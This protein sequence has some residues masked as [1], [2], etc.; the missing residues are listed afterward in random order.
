MLMAKTLQT[1][2]LILKIHIVLFLVLVSF[3]KSTLAQTLLL[4]GD[5]VFVSVNSSNNSFE[6]VPLIDLT[7][8]TTFEINNGLWNEEKHEF[9]NAE[10]LQ[11]TAIEAVSAGS[12]IYVEN[13][14]TPSFKTKGTLNIAKSSNHLF[15]YQKEEIQHRFIYAIGWQNQDKNKNSFQRSD[16]PLALKEVENSITE[17]SG[18][19]NYQYFIR[20]G[21]S[22]TP[23]MIRRFVANADHWKINNQSFKNLGTSFKLLKSPVINFGSSF[24]Q[25]NENETKLTLDVNIF[26]HDGSK[27][28]VD[29]VFDSVYSSITRNRISNYITQKVNFTGL[30]GDATKQIVL[31][32]VDDE[33]YSGDETAI[34]TLEN[35]S[36][37]SFGDFNNHTVI[38][39]EDEIPELK[40]EVVNNNESQFLLI[41]NLERNSVDVSNWQISNGDFD[42]IFEKGQN[43]EVGETLFITHNKAKEAVS[44]SAIL[45]DDESYNSLFVGKTIHLNNRQIKKVAEYAFPS[46]DADKSGNTEVFASNFSDVNTVNSEN[47]AVQQKKLVQ[48][49][50]L[51]GWKHIPLNDFESNNFDDIELKYW[52]ESK[53][54]FQKL[55]LQNLPANNTVLVGYF[56]DDNAERLRKLETESKEKELSTDLLTLSLSATDANENEKLDGVEGFSLVTNNTS[57]ALN[58]QEISK[59]IKTKL[60]LNIEPQLFKSNSS[61]SDIRS[62]KN[63]FILPNQQFWV[64]LN[65]KVEAQVIDINTSE[66]TNNVELSKK[67]ENEPGITLQLKG[68]FGKEFI[69]LNFNSD[70]E[71]ITNTINPSIYKQLYLNEPQYGLF[72]INMME[73][74]FSDYTI[75]E[76]ADYSVSLPLQLGALNDEELTISIQDWTEVPDDWVVQ[77]VD[78]T[79]EETYELN[80]NWEYTFDYYSTKLEETENDEINFPTLDRRF[81]LKF[82]PKAMLSKEEE[83]LPLSVELYQNYP[84]PFNPSTTISFFLP[85]EGK[86]KLAVFNIVGQPV[87]VLI[88]DVKSQGEYSIEWDASDVPSGMYIY[89]LEVGTKIMTR[90]MTLVK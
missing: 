34:F 37:G 29:V 17:L 87:A 65:E 84:N 56:D 21:A 41:H 14:K 32:F 55:D 64:K 35:A 1:K 8:G 67:D 88:D 66:L 40:I 31:T 57:L 19:A 62:I 74:S 24:N 80:A 4:P 28:T 52:N 78:E 53:A 76:K 71:V 30:M 26:E 5:I 3:S 25:L 13:G 9:T 15:A 59:Q 27:L 42:F 70:E 54:Q 69:K 18:G 44:T 73:Q 50:A 77:L 60:L 72:S 89:Q 10:K 22:G 51:P 46:K 16:I 38:V 45:L 47:V 61:F 83:N 43:L 86:V 63:E 82:V 79:E 7:K 33:I 85:E 11:F 49:K 81:T 12:I 6:I 75:A 2:A 23:Q 36:D 58:S 90:K 48:Q 20:N 68:K 39:R